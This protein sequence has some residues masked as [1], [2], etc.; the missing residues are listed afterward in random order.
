MTSLPLL[1]LL[2][3]R[4]LGV[5]AEKEATTPDYYPMTLNALVA[6]CNQKTNRNP[7][8]NASEAEVQATLDGLRRRTLVTES[9]GSRV[10]RFGHNLVKG[11]GLPRD[12]ILLLVV[13]WL[14][15]P[16]TPG[17]LRIHSE[18][19][20]QFEDIAA[21]EALLENMMERDV[22]LIVKLP[23]RPGS[24]EHRYAHLLS[25]PVQ[26]E[27]VA[28]EMLPTGS[29][30]V[31]TGEVAALKASVAQ[32]REEIDALRATVTRLCGELGVSPE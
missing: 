6:G 4:V 3:T 22:P 9:S 19:L 5:L 30:D 20:Q 11:L 31:T 18:R 24:R 13:L 25:G 8:I 7:V 10:S 16:Q 1:S 2:E 15:G 17:E 23:R 26:A 29:G 21:V 32:M 27:D 12:R 28:S 14:R